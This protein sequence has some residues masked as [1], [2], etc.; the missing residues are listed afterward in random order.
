MALALNYKD[1]LNVAV[2][3]YGYVTD[4]FL[5]KL[6]PAYSA[7]SST[8]K[9]YYHYDVAAAKAMLAQSKVPNGF[10]MTLK[11]AENSMF[12]ALAE[13]I[14]NQ[15]KVINITVNVTPEDSSVFSTDIAKGNF[16]AQMINSSNPDPA[17]VMNLLDGRMTF[18]Q[19]Q[20]GSGW[21]GSDDLYKLMDTAK[22]TID[23]TSR[24]AAY[25]QI[26]TIINEAVPAIP[27]VS[28]NRIITAKSNLKG[29]MLTV[30]TDTDLSRAYR[31]K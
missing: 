30:F 24:N 28:Q 10:T 8:D 29:I 12:K 18:Q 2:G 15:L 31:V 22:S 7:P 6:S 16:E 25:K 9:N 1:N 14:Q 19:V 5:P 4:S 27:L 26:Q 13:V 20:G 17:A 23:E 11:Y 3:T 21:K